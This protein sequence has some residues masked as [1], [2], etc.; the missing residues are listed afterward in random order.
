MMVTWWFAALVTGACL[1]L[2]L[3]GQIRQFQA[4]TRSEDHSIEML[5]ELRS[6]NTFWRDIVAEQ[7]A[8]A[9]LDT[10]R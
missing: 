7:R 5:T 6:L 10:L 2:I 3:V 4:T 8:R 1:A 9:R